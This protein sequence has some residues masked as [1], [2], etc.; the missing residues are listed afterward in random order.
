MIVQQPWTAYETSNSYLLVLSALQNG[1]LI[2]KAELFPSWDQHGFVYVVTLV[3][4]SERHQQVVLPKSELV[5]K[6]L[7]EYTTEACTR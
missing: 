4:D 5:E 1:W 3:H 2:C 6:L 7:A